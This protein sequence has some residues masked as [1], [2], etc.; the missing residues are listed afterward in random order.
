MAFAAHRA[1]SGSVCRLLAIEGT[2]IDLSWYMVIAILAHDF[3]H[4]PEER[5]P[6]HTRRNAYAHDGAAFAFDYQLYA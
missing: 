6:I 1:L 5:F 2:L 4:L 3:V